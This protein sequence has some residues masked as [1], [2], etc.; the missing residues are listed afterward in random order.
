MKTIVDLT[1]KLKEYSLEKDT[2]AKQ[3]VE[4]NIAP[5]EADDSSA[6][7]AY[8]VGEQLFL[9]DVLYDVTSPISVGDAIVVDTNITAANKISANIETLTN[10]VDDIVNVLGAKNL[11]PYPYGY[12]TRT[13]NGVTFTDNGDGTITL[14]GTNTSTSANT[15]FM[16]HQR[17]KSKTAELFSRLKKMNTSFKLLGGIN[18]PGVWL[19]LDFY[20]SSGTYVSSVMN[21][22][23]TP[24]QFTIPSNVED[25]NIFIRCAIDAVYSNLTLYPMLYLASITDDTYEPYAKT[26][27]EL[28]QD[29]PGLLDNTKVNGAVNMLPYPYSDSNKVDQGVTFIDNG[30]GTITVNGTNTGAN[31]SSFVFI[32]D[33]VGVIPAGTY[34][35]TFEGWS[36]DYAID[37]WYIYN[38]TT[39]QDIASPNSDTFTYNG[40]DVLYFR[41]TVKIGKTVSTTLKPMITVSSYNGDY[42]PYAKSNRELTEE[43]SED[44]ANVTENGI[45]ASF[46]KWGKICTV[47]FSGAFNADFA[48]DVTF[49]NIPRGFAPKVNCQ[50]LSTNKLSSVQDRIV[51]NIGYNGTIN[52]AVQNVA[53]GDALKGSFT[54]VTA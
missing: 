5:V 40:T 39:G 53:S 30:D 7:R 23:D 8:V 41:Y 16:L 20:D 35:C 3:A 15:V 54:Y 13:V 9:N 14:N 42:V 49:L 25:I 24:T 26:N 33:Q 22:S 34:K 47:S 19:V 38:R 12:T 46:R 31:I 2:A 10:E 28:T 48:Y 43:L 45:T 32:N 4:A 27:Q 18:S 37:W 6:S 17:N 21:R 52:V 44:S 29:T 36:G 1:E 51:L 50:M 11:L